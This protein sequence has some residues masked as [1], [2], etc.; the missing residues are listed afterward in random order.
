MVQISV[1]S[2]VQRN[3][4]EKI[5]EDVRMSHWKDWRWQLKN[6]IKDLNTESSAIGVEKLLSDY[7]KTISLVPEDNDRMERRYD[8]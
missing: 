3:V 2:K 6:S 4:A 8:E 1:Y 7:D 5:D